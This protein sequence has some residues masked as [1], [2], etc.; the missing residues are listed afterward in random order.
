MRK[1]S[2]RPA[3]DVDLA[4]IMT[5]VVRTVL[6]YNQNADKDKLWRAYR[7]ASEAHAGQQRKSGEP[8][9]LH[10][11]AVVQVL[12]ELRLDVDTLVAGMVHDVVEDTAIAI[13]RIASEF[14]DDV[15]SMVDGVTKIS[16]LSN[17]NPEAKQAENF[18]KLILY[19]AQDPRTVLIKLADRL[20]NMRTIEFLER[21]R[22]VAIAAETLDVYAPL[23]HR[24]GIAKIKWE[25]EDHAFKVLH[26]ER[27]FKIQTGINQSRAE[28]ERLIEEIRKPLV[29]AFAKAGIKATITGRPKHFFSIQR[30]ME[31]QQIGLDRMYDLL[32]LRI[33]TQNKTDCYHALGIIHT[34]FPP[35]RDR[36]R[37][38]IAAPKPNLYQ[39]IH[40]TVKVAGGKY[41]EMQIRTEAMH[42]NSELGIAAHWRYKE[43]S[44]DQTD[45][46]AIQKWLQQVMEWQQDVTDASEFMET[47]NIDFLQD[48]V[49]VFS[50]A[51]DL[52]P[53]PRGSTPLDFAFRI[54]SEVGLHCVGAKVN[55]RLVSM[56]TVLQNRDV[57]EIMT[58]R[59]A[60]P[61]TSWLGILKT[62]RAKHRVRR[63]IKATQ[64]QESIRL[65]RDILEREL[66]RKKIRL[67]VD[68]DL[69]DVAQEMGYQELDTLLAAV[70]SGDLPYQRVISR[71]EPPEKSRAGK[72]VEMGRDIYDSLVH[73]QVSGVKVAGVDNLMVNYARCCQ[74]IPGDE[75][76]GVITRGR[77]VTVHRN[78]CPNL[79]DPQF[80][81]RLIDVTWDSS[82]EQNF[83][84]KIIVTASDRKNLL[85]D[86]GQV[87]GSF[88]VN[89]KSAEFTSE[90]DLAQAIMLVEV[91]NLHSLEKVMVALTKVAA[92]HNVERYQLN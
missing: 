57:V 18:R 26:P 22:Q 7:F 67:N 31:M 51:G 30:K 16:E 65:G 14:G 6:A 9:F 34:L 62:G 90:H 80:L 75:I 76:I 60:T 84:V 82:P 12:S 70:G 56:R 63:W 55:G 11:L 71:I 20:H 27:Y 45:F 87:I 89:I 24:F 50:P 3:S 91:H 52:F 23:A 13:D 8:F 39:S 77:G 40:T 37:D 36:I 92:V 29:D 49:F 81:D 48:E 42:E 43:G 58:S 78:G 44:H 4:G 53:L 28:R 1:D 73:R 35:I 86:L 47:L 59:S 85:A 61:S 5:G 72:V 32:A 38:Y 66:A 64:F 10:G 21:D 17:V 25:L 79:N 15:A 74:P 68:R 83:V 54:H 19:I 46:S 41:V 69:V 88:G 33:I 2:P